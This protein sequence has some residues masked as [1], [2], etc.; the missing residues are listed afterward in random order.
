MRLE[1]KMRCDLHQTNC[2]IKVKLKHKQFLLLHLIRFK[3]LKM[4][5]RKI[6][7]FLSIS[8]II[9]SL[10]KRLEHCYLNQALSHSLSNRAIHAFMIQVHRMRIANNFMI[11]LSQTASN[12]R[13]FGK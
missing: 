9:L 10:T 4:L 3:C 12:L 13:A 7:N 8:V 1:K 2:C 5:R 11:F 6:F